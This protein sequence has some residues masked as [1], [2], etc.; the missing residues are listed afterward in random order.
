[1]IDVEKVE[2]MYVFVIEYNRIIINLVIIFIIKRIEYSINQ[3][4]SLLL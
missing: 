4:C 3:Y 1:M 2:I